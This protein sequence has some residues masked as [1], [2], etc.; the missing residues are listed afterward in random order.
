MAI[1]QGQVSCNNLPDCP[2]PIFWN[3]IILTEQKNITPQGFC[4]QNQV[5][6]VA[7]DQRQGGGGDGKADGQGGDL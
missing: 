7:V 6:G 1:I 4:R 3:D 5:K 2:C